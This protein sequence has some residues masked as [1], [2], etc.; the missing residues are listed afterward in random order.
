MF[1]LLAG[2]WGTD[3]RN[4][5][6]GRTQY[7]KEMA[8]GQH[9]IATHRLPAAISTGAELRKTGRELSVRSQ[10]IEFCFR[11]G[12]NRRAGIGIFPT[13]EEFAISIFRFGLVSLKGIGAS[14]LEMR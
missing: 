3:R 2:F 9:P 6:C 5:H 12:G 13:R 4:G 1:R 10:L 8:G 7:T 14:E 11:K